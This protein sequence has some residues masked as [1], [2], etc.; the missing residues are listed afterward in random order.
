LIALIRESDKKTK[1]QAFL[2]D[3]DGSKRTSLPGW[4]RF[5]KL[6]GKS[7]SSRALYGQS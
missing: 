4:E 5:E 3:V 7:T 2:E 6:V 1:L